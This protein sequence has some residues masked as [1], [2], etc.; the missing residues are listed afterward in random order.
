M[1]SFELVAFIFYE[2]LGGVLVDPPPGYEVL[3]NPGPGRVKHLSQI[4]LVTYKKN[5]LGITFYPSFWY[6]QRDIVLTIF[7]LV[8]QKVGG[9][10]DIRSRFCYRRSFDWPFSK[11]IY[12]VRHDILF[13][14]LKPTVL[15]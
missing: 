6:M 5:C 12:Y 4:I 2:I 11:K 14:K 1:Q 10:G 7:L 8:L 13:V 15:M 9:E 3:K